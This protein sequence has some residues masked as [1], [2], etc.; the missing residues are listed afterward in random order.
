MALNEVDLGRKMPVEHNYAIPAS[1][2]FLPHIDYADDVDFICK[3][4]ENSEDLLT[5]VETSFAKYQLRLTTEI[6]FLGGENHNIAKIKK[7]WIVFR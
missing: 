1:T 3:P 5:L 4:N 6:S 7:T 2:N